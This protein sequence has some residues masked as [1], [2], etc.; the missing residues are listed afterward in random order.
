MTKLLRG[1]RLLR[2]GVLRDFPRTLDVLEAGDLI[3][4]HDRNQIFGLVTLPLRRNFLAVTHA[5]HRQSSR[6]IPAPSNFEH[7][8]IQQGLGQNVSHRFGT[9]VGSYRLEFKAVCL[10]E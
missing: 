7:R 6:C 10:P 5:L 4:K 3:R 2:Q 1:D 8:R 9:Q